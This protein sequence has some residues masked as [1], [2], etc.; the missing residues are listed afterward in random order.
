[1]TNKKTETKDEQSPELV[2]VTL[3]TGADWVLAS[4]EDK[5]PP[6]TETGTEMTREQAD[7]ALADANTANL[8]IEEL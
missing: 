2:L 4:R 8:H 1:M 3:A 6:I 5:Y 7:L